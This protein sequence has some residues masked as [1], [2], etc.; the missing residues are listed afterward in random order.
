M[1]STPPRARGR[2]RKFAGPSRAVT[3]TLPEETLAQLSTVHD[4]VSHAIVRLAGSQRPAKTHRAPAEL[5]TY[6]R[7]AVII[8]RPTPSLERRVGIDLVPLP[9]GRALISFD[10]PTTIPELELTLS[11]ALEDA[12]LTAAERQVFESIRAILN[13]ARRSS[14]VTLLRRSIIVLEYHGKPRSQRIVGRQSG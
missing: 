9:D 5:A 8:I 3:L 4:D 10:Q 12:S 14:R 13:E 7:R 11:D 6:G 2:P 1:A